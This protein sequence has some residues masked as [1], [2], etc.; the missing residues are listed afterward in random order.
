MQNLMEALRVDAGLCETV[1]YA[2]A[3]FFDIAMGKW[4]KGPNG[5]DK[6]FTVM[7]VCSISAVVF[8]SGFMQG[9]KRYEDNL[10][11]T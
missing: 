2:G 3:M 6:M 1:A 10:I 8:M 4:L 7:I 5:Y 11:N 9:E